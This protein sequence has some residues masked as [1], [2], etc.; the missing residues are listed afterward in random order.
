[1][2]TERKTICNKSSLERCTDE[3]YTPD[4][5]PNDLLYYCK[6]RHIILWTV[7][8]NT[9]FLAL[10]SLYCYCFLRFCTLKEG[11]SVQKWKFTRFSSFNLVIFPICVEFLHF[12]KDKAFC[13]TSLL[14]RKHFSL[15]ALNSTSS[16]K[17]LFK[18]SEREEWR[19]MC[20]S[21][22]LAM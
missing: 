14:S 5:I 19:E 18:C 3:E 4:K 16:D 9:A 17:L 6:T 11:C 8:Q 13:L 22:P 12:G 2:T 21:I 1:M 7:S 10:F 20:Q 15:T